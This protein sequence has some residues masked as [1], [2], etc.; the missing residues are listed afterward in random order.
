M[1]GGDRCPSLTSVVTLPTPPHPDIMTLMMT[2]WSSHMEPPATLSGSGE[3]HCSLYCPAPAPASS[4]GPPR[5]RPRPR[6]G[7]RGP[8]VARPTP[9]CPPPASGGAGGGLFHVWGFTIF[10]DVSYYYCYLLCCIF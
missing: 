7:S 9:G 1:C 2:G 10:L 3:A 5:P 4:R 8:L 6:E